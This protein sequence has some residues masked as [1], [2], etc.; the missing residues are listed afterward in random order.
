MTPSEKES[1]P[2]LFIVMNAGSGDKTAEAREATIREVLTEAGRPHRIWRVTEKSQLGEIARQAVQ[3]AQK[4]NG[5]VVA[6]GG[7]GTLSTVAQAVLGSGCPYGVLPQGTFNYFSRAHRLPLDTAAAARVLV[8]GRVRHVHVGLVNDRVFL[9]NAS[10]GLYPK[11]LE[12]REVHKEMF[13]RTRLVAMFSALATVLTPPPRLVLTLEEGGE[14]ELLHISTLLV[15]NSPLQL[16]EVG[17]PEAG[18][19]K[20]GELAAVIVKAKGVWQI[21]GV[22]ARAALGKLREAENV[23]SFSFTSITVDPLHRRRI[24][25]ATDGEI[26]WLTPPLV[27]RVAP[28]TLPLILPPAQSA[29]P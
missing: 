6:A 8:E 4:E 3:M 29:Q 20:R 10:L 16:E 28:H 9:V 2:P 14:R 25:V 18:D 27:F 26:N 12:K 21:L 19:V 13:G 24:K 5:A 17:L 7:D 23:S 15:E 22:V 1:T 11:L